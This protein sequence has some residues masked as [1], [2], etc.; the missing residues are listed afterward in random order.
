MHFNC[1]QRRL[2]RIAKNGVSSMSME[3][4]VNKMWT[5]ICCDYDFFPLTASLRRAMRLFLVTIMYLIDIII[6]FLDKIY[7]KMS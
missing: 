2:P 3:H 4:I 7:I 1:I 5:T 6:V